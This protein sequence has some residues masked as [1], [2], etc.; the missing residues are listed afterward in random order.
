MMRSKG[1]FSTFFYATSSARP[2]SLAAWPVVCSLFLATL[3]L[4]SCVSTPPSTALSGTLNLSPAVQERVAIEALLVMG[5]PSALESVV[6]LTAEA[7]HLSVDQVLVYDWLAHELARLVYPELMGSSVSPRD[8]PQNDPLIRQFVD[9]RN[10]R[11]I[12][13]GPNASALEELLPALMV[14]RFRNLESTSTALNALERFA[15]FGQPS[16]LAYLIR[17]M[18]LERSGDLAAAAA[19]LNQAIALAEDNYQAR[20]A[21]AN[22]LVRRSAAADALAM[23]DTVDPLLSR[24]L[25]YRRARASALY[26]AGRYTEALPMITAVLQ[27][28]PMNSSLLLMRAHLLV[29]NKE[30]RQAQPLLEA[31]ASV[32]ANSRLYLLLRA[33][34][35][36]E[37]GRDRRSA[38]LYLRRALDRYPEDSE[39]ILYTANVLAT[40]GSAQEQAEAL[41]LA[42]RV[43]SFQPDSRE[44]IRIL[45][46]AELRSADV[47]AAV[48]YADRLLG[49]GLAADDFELV[50][51]AYREAGRTSLAR[52]V[53]DAWRASQP[54]SEGARLAHI[55][56]LVEGG[57]R[58]Q[59]GSLIASY[60]G[61][62]GSQA[63]KSSL[64]YLNSRIQ[65]NP[66]AVLNSLR[67]A[68]IEDSMNIDALLAMYDIYEAGR[69]YQRAA[70][71][72]KQ[73]FAIAPTRRDVLTRR[74]SMNQLGI[75]IP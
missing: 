1:G 73:A 8:V 51:T 57:D 43:L 22:L 7:R 30:Y 5:S 38:L 59:A 32:D 53:A 60:L 46:A 16:S 39:L 15:G 54:E 9:A 18:A 45:L 36:L 48:E 25:A 13:P 24:S 17:G 66:D 75:A 21:L 52:Q 31:Y 41:A 40:G 71:Y 35:A 50:Y 64:H 34:L 49:L 11:P 62:R 19:A 65:T 68:L 44:A 67:N 12:Q 2:R 14:F 6:R 56:M 42:E 26:H 29:E 69:D 74:T 70:F 72:L 20:L 58:S 10:G 4:S 55:T 37:Q 63:Y 27:E 47:F 61:G 28:E 23:L 3:L 33:R